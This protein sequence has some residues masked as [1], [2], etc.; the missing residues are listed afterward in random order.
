MACAQSTALGGSR[1]RCAAPKFLGSIGFLQ[2]SVTHFLF[3]ATKHRSGF[4][5][6]MAT[7]IKG[8]CIMTCPAR[9][10]LDSLDLLWSSWIARCAATRRSSPTSTVSEAPG[11]KE[12]IRA[13]TTRGRVITSKPRRWLRHKLQTSPSRP[14]SQ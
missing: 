2:Q 3:H 12:D 13:W 6:C 4:L 14:R 11:R 9:C 7:T 10:A 8:P 5:C 1:Q